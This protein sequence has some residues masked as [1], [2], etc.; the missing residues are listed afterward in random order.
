MAVGKKITELIKEVKSN[1]SSDGTLVYVVNNN[2]SRQ[3]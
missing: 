1:L 2:V 3:V